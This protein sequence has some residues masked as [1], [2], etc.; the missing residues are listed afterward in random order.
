MAKKSSFIDDQDRPDYLADPQG[1]GPSY[2][3]GDGAPTSYASQPQQVIT[4]QTPA[5]GN[6]PPPAF[7]DPD[8][9]SNAH[10][11]ANPTDA[12]TA[13]TGKAS[14]VDPDLDPNAYSPVNP[15]A[16]GSVG[17]P[18]K[19]K[20]AAQLRQEAAD[21]AAQRPDKS[22]GIWRTLAGI[23]AGIGV[24]YLTRNPNMVAQVQGQIMHPGAAKWADDM[25]AKELAAEHAE[26]IETDAQAAAKGSADLAKIQAEA[27]EAN[28][29]AK[30]YET[31]NAPPPPKPL[32]K[33]DV[34]EVPDSDGKIHLR[35][36]PNASDPTQF[37]EIGLKDPGPPKELTTSNFLER[38]WPDG[39][40]H[41]MLP[42]PRT[43]PT[44]IKPSTG[45]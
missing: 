16:S 28:A 45:V 14:Y 15:T 5:P 7:V 1:D 41:W 34:Q 31:P 17:T 39:T 18:N 12:G 19:P 32:S 33:T 22:P 26:K 40:T 21:L 10:S 44:R 43:Q 11:A 8:P 13:P 35:V 36:Y 24:G 23:G 6:M 30:Y 29:R 2:V 25:N 9:V 38:V 37:T 3:S 20:T 42:D 4:A 27:R